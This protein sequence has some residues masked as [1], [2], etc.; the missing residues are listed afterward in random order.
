MMAAGE[1]FLQLSDEMSHGAWRSFYIKPN[2]LQPLI[3]YLDR[4]PEAAGIVRAHCEKRRR[5]VARQKAK[6]ERRKQDELRKKE[7]APPV[8]TP[9]AMPETDAVERSLPAPSATTP[10]QEK[11]NHHTSHTSSTEE[12]PS[13]G[14]LA[15]YW[16]VLPTLFLAA[17]MV[18]KSGNPEM[19]I[20]ILGFGGILWF[21][22]PI[23][24]GIGKSTVERGANALRILGFLCVVGILG[25][26][27]PSSCTNSSSGAPTGTYFRR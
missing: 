27:L 5:E 6:A 8:A 10:Q 26:F 12:G 9:A 25:A 14:Q 15:A 23:W 11:N 22:W 2:M 1:P 18:E 20:K 17:M 4:N 3:S 24:L 19:A 21:L 7:A 13:R 16:A